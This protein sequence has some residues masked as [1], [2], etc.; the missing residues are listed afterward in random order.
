MAQN[1]TT[2]Y[3]IFSA[4]V[5]PGAVR[6]RISL[7]RIDSFSFHLQLEISKCTTPTG[8]Q[9]C[10]KLIGENQQIVSIDD[11]EKILRVRI[12]ELNRSSITA[13]V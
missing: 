1:T 6:G 2:I 9:R 13:G 11:K 5:V 7:V 3:D 10:Q 8:C 12:L 4:K